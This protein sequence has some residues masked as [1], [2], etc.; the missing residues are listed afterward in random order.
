MRNLLN[1]TVGGWIRE[2]KAEMEGEGNPCCD[3]CWNGV[4]D[5]TDEKC[6]EHPE[7]PIGQK[8]CHKKKKLVWCLDDASDCPDF[9]S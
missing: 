3:Q 1:K 8:W 9:F 7:P 5:P 4:C 6:E 2:K